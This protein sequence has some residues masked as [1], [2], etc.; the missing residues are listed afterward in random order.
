MSEYR[1]TS[2]IIKKS[3]AKNWDEA[4]LEWA[5]R[6][7]YEA[8]GPETCL[9][10]HYPIIELC[11][12]E[13]KKNGGSATVGNF[14]VKKFIGLPSDKIFEAVKRVR[15]DGTKSLNAEAIDHAYQRGWI[16]QWEKEFYF[17]NMRKRKL[18]ARQKEK[19]TQINEKM[20]RNMRRPQTSA[21]TTVSH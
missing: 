11:V 9:C 13:N 1:L 12:L 17:Q 3:V 19:K 18:S 5:L 14:C 8:D 15:K 6:E 16:N 2:E 10:G 21:R 4:K 20:L 7:V